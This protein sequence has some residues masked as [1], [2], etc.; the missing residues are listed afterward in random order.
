[1][2]HRLVIIL[3]LLEKITQFVFPVLLSK[4]IIGTFYNIVWGLVKKTSIY[5]NHIKV[6][7]SECKIIFRVCT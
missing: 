6:Y 3:M 5:I 1:M 4:S 7:A 2:W